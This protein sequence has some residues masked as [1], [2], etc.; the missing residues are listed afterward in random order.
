MPIDHKSLWYVLLLVEFRMRCIRQVPRA[1]CFF[2]F[3]FWSMVLD[4]GSRL[5]LIF[6][7]DEDIRE[8]PLIMR[9]LKVCIFTAWESVCRQTKRGI[10]TGSPMFILLTGVLSF[11]DIVLEWIYTGCFDY[12]SW[13]IETN[14]DVS[15]CS[16]S[17]ELILCWMGLEYPGIWSILSLQSKNLYI[18]W[19]VGCE[20]TLRLLLHSY[21]PFLQDLWM[22]L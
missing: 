1:F 11:I 19:L 10:V 15:Y 2:C 16:A 22:A 18:C 7:N 17:K 5:G 14:K 4:L 3:T 13:Q 9:S 8:K 21:A 20:R 6:V 12:I